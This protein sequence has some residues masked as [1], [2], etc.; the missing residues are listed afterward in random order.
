MRHPAVGNAPAAR[1]LRVSRE[2]GAL[3][4]NSGPGKQ[5][6]SKL[7]AGARVIAEWPGLS[8]SA[9]ARRHDDHAPSV[10]RRWGGPSAAGLTA[11]EANI[12]GGNAEELAVQ[13]QP[14]PEEG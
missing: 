5:N 4:G 9:R 14:L 7:S 2:G 6:R 12:P 1:P 13:G 10:A 3:W 11:R 8:E